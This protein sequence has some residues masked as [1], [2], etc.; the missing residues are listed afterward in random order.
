M[1]STTATA[2]Q[3]IQP[4]TTAYIAPSGCSNQFDSVYIE[5]GGHSPIGDFLL[6]VSLSVPARHPPC[7]P[8]GWN[9]SQSTLS[10][11]PA[12][13]PS[14]WTAYGLKAMRLYP[15]TDPATLQSSALC[16]S[17]D[18]QMTGYKGDICVS[19]VPV[20]GEDGGLTT[21]TSGL[22]S[23][24]VKA[25]YPWSIFWQ[26]QDVST[27]SPSPPT[28]KDCLN[29]QIATWVPGTPVQ[30][31]NVESCVPWNDGTDRWHFTDRPELMFAV[32]GVPIMLLGLVALCY[33]YWRVRPVQKRKRRERK[34]RQML[35]GSAQGQQQSH[36][37]GSQQLPP[38]PT[39]PCD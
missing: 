21:S 1:T 27:L 5:T 15:S 4:L 33:W 11:C 20:T 34:K 12:V 3:A 8:A 9:T 14:G 18:T 30:A 16:C 7:Q 25:H 36:D 6:Q 39:T 23:F 37:S 31:K 28:L 22:P 35:P 24:G 32:I 29:T 2:S 38:K 17:S 19:D 10:F 13:C 26:S